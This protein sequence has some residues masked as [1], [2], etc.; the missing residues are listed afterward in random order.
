[1]EVITMEVNSSP[2]GGPTLEE[3]HAEIRAVMR[4]LVAGLFTENRNTPLRK[5]VES[6]DSLA[7]VSQPLEVK[8]AVTQPER[9]CSG[10]Q[11]KRP[12]EVKDKP[13]HPD[14]GEEVDYAKWHLNQKKYKSMS[15]AAIRR[16]VRRSSLEER[17]TGL[18]VLAAQAW[19]KDRCWRNEEWLL[20]T[21]DELEALK[22]ERYCRKPD[23]E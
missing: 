4:S 7:L 3:R 17:I 14:I 11:D 6:S 21:L 12:V 23:R 1:L 13:H 22:R 19:S 5:P 9:D 10:T 16:S 18:V 15:R 2:A 8:A 20:H